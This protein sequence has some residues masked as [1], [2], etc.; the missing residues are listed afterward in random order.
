MK[1][2]AAKQME[3]WMEATGSGGGSQLIAV[4]RGAALRCIRAVY[5]LLRLLS[6]TFADFGMQ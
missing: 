1:D 5:R 3:E 6:S 2:S 4:Y